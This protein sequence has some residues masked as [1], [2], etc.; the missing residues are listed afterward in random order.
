MRL[1]NFLITETQRTQRI[2][3]GVEVIRFDECEEKS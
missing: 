3:I 2:L 1:C